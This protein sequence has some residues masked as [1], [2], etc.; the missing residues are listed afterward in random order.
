MGAINGVGDRPVGIQGEDIEEGNV[1][2]ASREPL[3]SPS[4]YKPCVPGQT[5]PG[6]VQLKG[7]FSS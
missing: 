3:L 7:P 5:E 6:R 2:V 4:I 1:L